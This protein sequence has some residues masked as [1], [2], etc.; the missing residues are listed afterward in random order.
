M[1]RKRQATADVADINMTPMIDCTFQLIIFFVL[2]AQMVSADLAKLKP[3]NPHESMASAEEAIQDMPNKVIVNVVNEYLDQ[4]DDPK[5]GFTRDSRISAKAIAYKISTKSIWIN[6]APKKMRQNE[7]LSS[8]PEAELVK[9]L[10]K[11]KGTYEA[12]LQEGEDKEFFVEIRAD[13]DIRFSDIKV[14][15]DAAVKARIGKMSITAIVNE[16]TKI[17][18]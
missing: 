15:I 11:R 7:S 1:P 18:K 12:D 10:E 3:A 17:K 9:I 16:K 6:N 13:K 5:K 14:V 4:D 8:D 2:T